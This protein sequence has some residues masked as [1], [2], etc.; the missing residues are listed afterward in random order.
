MRFR[1]DRRRGMGTCTALFQ[2]QSRSPLK[3]L[4][5]GTLTWLLCL[6][7]LELGCA[8]TRVKDSPRLPIYVRVLGYVY[9][10]ADLDLTLGYGAGL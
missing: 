6:R 5:H 1:R 4:P 2:G 7:I 9:V 3:A 8:P 10:I